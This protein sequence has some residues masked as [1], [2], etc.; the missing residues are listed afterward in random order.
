MEGPGL[1]APPRSP[2]SQGLAWGS[3]D[4]WLPSVLAKNTRTVSQSVVPWW[5][6]GL[7]AA[8]QDP[9]TCQAPHMVL[10]ANSSDHSWGSEEQGVHLSPLR[11]MVR[12]GP[13]LL[14]GPARMWVPVQ[15]LPI[16]HRRAKPKPEVRCRHGAQEA[17]ATSC[18]SVGAGQQPQ[19]VQRLSK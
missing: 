1:S 16:G 12:S 4:R 15:P 18:P 13:F 3:Q 6:R 14:W 5:A 7:A 10:G 2:F 17:L 11:Q 9:A 8:V 19:S